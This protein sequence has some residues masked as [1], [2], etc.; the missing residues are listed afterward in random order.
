MKKGCG[1][2]VATGAGSPEPGRWTWAL[3]WV[4]CV[5]S[6]DTLTF[7]H[8]D[9]CQL[10]QKLL[11]QLSSDR[12]D[13]RTRRH[14][15]EV[16][17]EQRAWEICFLNLGSSCFPHFYSLLLDLGRDLASLCVNRGF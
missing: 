9:F 16:L 17:P 1:G 14:E 5:T 12:S 13:Q 3:L 6:I 10:G 7:L 4:C 8:L 15:G 11:A 2:L